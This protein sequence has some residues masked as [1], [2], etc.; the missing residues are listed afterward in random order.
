[1]GKRLTTP[2]Q[3]LTAAR[4]LIAKKGWCQGALARTIAGGTVPTDSPGAASW[5]MVGA[6]E[7]CSNDALPLSIETNARRLIMSALDICSIPAWNDHP[8]R[9][10]AEVLAAF[11][12][13]IKIAKQKES[14][15]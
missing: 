7:H 13:A 6:I 3:V 14:A 5:C 8:G 10:K 4:N 2:R 12:K 9:T 11:D 15:Q 1:M